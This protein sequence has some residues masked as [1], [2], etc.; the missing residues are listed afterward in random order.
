MQSR[1]P[2]RVY[3]DFISPLFCEEIIDD[4]NFTVPDYDNSNRP[5]LTTKKHEGAEKV[6]YE[7]FL[8]I[9]PEITTYY[10]V[11]HKGTERPR[12]E[13]YPQG[14]NQSPPVCENSN[15]IGDKKQWARM[16]DRD[17]TFVLFLSDYN[18]KAPIDPDFEVYGGKLEFPQHQFGFNPERGTLICYPSGP[19]FANVTSAVQAG[20]LFQCRF[21]I[22]CKTP[23]IY[24]P[25][26]FPGDYR[27]WFIDIA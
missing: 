26:E 1:S 19:H 24:R 27:S 6:V 22:A 16:R 7:K 11:E 2:F 17:F 20:N 5:I 10:G 18:N 13:W 15:R 8:Q 23:Y 9:L 3:Q 12:F 14:C 21:H 4:L 25:K